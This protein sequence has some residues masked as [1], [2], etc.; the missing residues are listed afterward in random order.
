[1]ATAA[2]AKIIAA[3]VVNKALVLAVAAAHLPHQAPMVVVVRRWLIVTQEFFSGIIN[4]AP[5]DCVGKNFYTRDGFINAVNSYSDLGKR[6]SV[7]ESKREI[8]A[9]FAHA[10]HETGYFC[11]IEEDEAT[12]E[13]A[14][15]PSTDYPCNPDKKYYGRGPFQITW[16][17]NYG[18]AGK[19]IGLDLLNSP[20]TVASD[21]AVAFKTAIWYWVGNV[22]S[23]LSQGFGA[24]TRAINGAKECD[25]QN[26]AAVQ[27]RA[28]LYKSYC[29]QFN[30]DPG[31]NL[32]C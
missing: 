28:A 12:R 16:N 29:S 4:Q 13:T 14:C 15:R 21:A 24:T 8:A 3:R 25:G 9:F 30:V 10:T 5:S 32:S 20:E 19:S 31:T 22:R 1:M 7:D 17:Y 23:V 2:A 26:S 27:A 11:F 18:P 6:G